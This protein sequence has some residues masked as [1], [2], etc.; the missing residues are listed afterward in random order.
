MAAEPST[1]ASVHGKARKVLAHARRHARRVPRAAPQS[2]DASLG[3]LRR[4]STG[5]PSCRLRAVR[6]HANGGR[7]ADDPNAASRPPLVARP[8]W[9]ARVARPAARTGPPTTCSRTPASARATR[10]IRPRRHAIPD[11]S[12]WLSDLEGRSPTPAICPFLRS[13]GTGDVIGFPVEAPDVANRCAALREPVPQSLRQQELVCLTAGHVNC[14]RYLR[15]ALVASDAPAEAAVQPGRSRPAITVALA[16][17]VAVVRRLGRVRRR[18]RRADLA[19]RGGRGRAPRRR[20][21]RPRSRP[22]GAPGRP[23]RP[24]RRRRIGGRAPSPAPSTAP[25][26]RRRRRPRRPRRHPSRRRRP[27]PK[28]SSNRYALLKPCPD[29]PDCW[30]YTSGRATTS[31]ASRTTSASP[32]DG[33]SAQPLDARPRPASRPGA[34]PAATPTR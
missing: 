26:R 15:G 34:D 27:K 3:P 24:Y 20:A 1:A 10:P 6:P 25:S 13:V 21:R 19:G 22:S 31:S 33:Q 28:P 4:P 12:T 7:V 30:I 29:K 32:R 5:S 2:D 11:P 16:V 17:L 18:Q 8:A 23:E 9:A 14:P